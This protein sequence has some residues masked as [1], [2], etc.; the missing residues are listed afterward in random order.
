GRATVAAVLAR[1]AP[2]EGMRFAEAGEFTR[3]AFL[4]GKLD[5]SAAEALSDLIAAETEAQRRL[6]L[7][8]AEGRQRELYMGWRGGILALRAEIEAHL[9]F[10]DQEDVPFALP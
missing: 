1:L 8:G 4:N 10:S 9:D 5:L 6:A 3:R 7:L 2:L